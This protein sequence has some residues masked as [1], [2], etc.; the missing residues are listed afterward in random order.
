[1]DKVKI[2]EIKKRIQ[3]VEEEHRILDEKI[4]LLQSNKFISQKMDEDLKKMKYEKLKKKKELFRLYE[5]LKNTD[6]T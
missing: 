6:N 1:M 4:K 2:E 3:I 5:L